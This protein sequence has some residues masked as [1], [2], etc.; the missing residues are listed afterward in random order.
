[1]PI[2]EKGTVYFVREDREKQYKRAMKRLKN[3]VT[4]WTTL[5]SRIAY[6]EYRI[7]RFRREGGGVVEIEYTYEGLRIHERELDVIEQRMRNIIGWI[8]ILERQLEKCNY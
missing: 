3:T 6:A 5:R 8:T 2:N 1:M 7:D 4:R